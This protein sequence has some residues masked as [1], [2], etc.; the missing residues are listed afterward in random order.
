M[1]VRPRLVP[2]S[3]AR[4]EESR[5]RNDSKEASN[6]HHDQRT[7]RVLRAEYAAGTDELHWKEFRTFSLQ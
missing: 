1:F 4:S 6:V 2:E 7:S 3:P 5:R